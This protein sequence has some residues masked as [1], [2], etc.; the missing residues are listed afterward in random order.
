[1]NSTSSPSPAAAGNPDAPTI[2]SCI[3]GSVYSRS[4]TLHS[5]WA[6]RRMNAAVQVLHTIAAPGHAAEPMDLS[7]SLGVDTRDEL[8]AELVEIEQARN[9]LARERGKALLDEARALLVA[10]GV[11]GVSTLQQHGSLVEVVTRIEQDQT[12]DLLVI[13][14]RGEAVDFATM[15]LGSN[16]ERVIRSSRAPVLVA[17]RKFEPIERFLVAYDGGPSV[18]KAIRYAIERPLL[19]GLQCRLLR[20][21]RIDDKAEWYLQE[22]AEKLRQAG[23]AV[24]TAAVPGDPDQ[25]IAEQVRREGI[26][27][28]VMGAY[29]HSRIRQ[30]II[31]STTT[32][33]VRTCLVPVLMFR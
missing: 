20:A 13:G 31:G 9:R 24:E 18:E 27:L 12:P 32:A 11:A 15:H 8:L 30:L 5:A 23:F 14:K 3:D 1:M 25:V 22:A 33:M 16:L 17:A 2:L 28:L 4:V 7:G 10:E 29:G 26:Q 6:A 21:G 19:R